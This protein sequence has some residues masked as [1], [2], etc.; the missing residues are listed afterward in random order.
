MESYVEESNSIA[1]IMLEHVSW[2]GDALVVS[3]PKSKADQSGSQ[4]FPRH[5][6]ANTKHPEICPVLAFAVL[7]FTKSFR[8]DA[9]SKSVAKQ[10]KSFP[11]FDGSDNEGRFSNLLKSLTAKMDMNTQNCLGCRPSELGTHSIRKGA[12]SYCNG[13]VDG[14]T[15]AQVYLRAGWS[16]GNVQDRYLFAGQGSDQ[17]IGRVLSGLSFS[18]REFAGLPAHFSKPG[19]EAIKWN[20]IL[21]IF[22]RLPQPF[23]QAL[24]YLLASIVHNE[25]FLRRS[26]DPC[27]PLFGSMLFTS[28]QIA[29][30]KPFVL[31]GNNECKETGM[32]AT[33]IPHVIVLATEVHGLSKETRENRAELK[34]EICELR[35]EMKEELPPMLTRQILQHIDVNGAVPVTMPQIESLFGEMQA[36]L[37]TLI[38]MKSKPPA[39]APIHAAP[40]Q[41]NFDEFRWKDGLIRFIP[42]GY[43]FPSTLVKENWKL[44]FCGNQSARIRPYRFLSKF[45]Y[46]KELSV[47]HSSMRRIV[48][49]TVAVGKG[50]LDEESDGKFDKKVLDQLIDEVAALNFDELMNFFDV[51]FSKLFELMKPITV[52]QNR[53]NEAAIPTVYKWILDKFKSSQK[54]RQPRRNPIPAPKPRSN[55]S[56]KQRR[57]ANPSSKSRRRNERRANRSSPPKRRRIEDEKSGS[58][59]DSTEDDEN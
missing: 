58:D 18:D 40:S 57:L 16:L 4:C 49:L 55:D 9:K 29:A 14:P 30:L 54:Q 5:I 8:I 32:K 38:E 56:N 59:V 46:G 21:P 10:A 24:P 23:Q 17:L 44:W 41:L 33:G 12:A 36:T 47:H 2:N 22:H 11:L 53:Y 43:V 20:E 26:L 34:Q 28:T 42:E 37:T 1:S 39:P 50:M 31:T 19:L 48:A 35:R 27:H 25:E 7:T 52:L 6:Y 45:D 15:T 51:N 13:L 3:I